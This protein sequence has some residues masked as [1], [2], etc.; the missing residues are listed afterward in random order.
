[1]TTAI[2]VL[3]SLVKQMCRLVAEQPH[4]TYHFEIGRPLAERLGYHPCCWTESGLVRSSRLLASG[5]SLA[6]H[7]SLTGSK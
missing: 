4:G 3:K 1:M 7:G 2:E 6:S 5:M